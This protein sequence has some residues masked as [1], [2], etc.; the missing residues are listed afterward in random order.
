MHT[1]AIVGLG[2]LGGSVA[3]AARSRRLAA[4]YLGYDRDP[5]VCELAQRLGLVDAA[6]PDLTDALGAAEVVVI[7]TPVASVV[8]TVERVLPLLAPGSL[9]TD[10]ASTKSSIA[11]TASRLAAARGCAFVGAHP[12]AG[13]Q[14]SGCLHA[15][16]DLFAGRL[17]V[18]TPTADNTPAQIERASAFWQSLGAQV[19][20]MSP[21]D[22]DRALAF[23]SHLPHLLASALIGCIPPEWVSVSGPGLRDTTRIA[24]SQPT[25]WA[26]IFLD[27]RLAL[28]LAVD[29]FRHRL[30]HLTSSLAAADRERL[31]H[32]LQE[33]KD[34]RD[35]LG[36]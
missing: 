30:D 25:L 8:A 23:T 33:G 15:R 20:P 21:E 5:Q 14:Q 10:T 18:L 19:R 16:A 24:A 4:R 26:D 27:N 36:S 12:L 11:A 34:V 32:L 22:H 35:Q 6:G 31:L 7:C 3:A 9:I 13:S 1:L 29:A 17:T 2:L 28:M